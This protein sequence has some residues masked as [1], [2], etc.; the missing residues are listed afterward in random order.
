MYNN[1]FIEGN[2]IYLRPLQETDATEEYLKWLNDYE[3]VKYTESRFY[4]NSMDSLRAYLTG[5]NNNNNVAFAIVEKSSNNHIGNIK[6]GNINW[7][8]RYADIGLIIGNKDYW[9][10]GIAPEVLELIVNYAF[11]RLNLRK[12]VAGAYIENKGSIRAF[13]KVGFVQAYTE[14]SKYFFEGRYIDSVV[15]ELFS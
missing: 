15:L 7:I 8:H 6:L 12:L 13:E 1:C 14:K 9:G 11:K 3:V 10:K 2:R 5:L 4:P